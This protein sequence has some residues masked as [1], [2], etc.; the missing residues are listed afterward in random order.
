MQSRVHRP[1][2]LAGWIR[3]AGELFFV[4]FGSLCWSLD[5]CRLI[6]QIRLI[7]G[8]TLLFA[9]SCFP[10]MPV[11]LFTCLFCLR[12]RA[13]AFPLAL[14]S[15][16]AFFLCFHISLVARPRAL[17][18]S[19][20]RSVGQSS[21]GLQPLRSLLRSFRTSDGRRP[22][23]FDIHQQLGLLS[24]LSLSDTAI[25]LF[26]LVLRMSM[27][28]ALR[29]IDSM[30]IVG[31]PGRRPCTGMR[32]PGYQDK[33]PTSS[34]SRSMVDFVFFFCSSFRFWDDPLCVEHCSNDSLF[35]PN[36]ATLLSH[37][38][39]PPLHNPSL[40]S[41]LPSSSPFNCVF[42][43]SLCLSSRDQLPLLCRRHF[44]ISSVLLCACGQ[45]LCLT[46]FIRTI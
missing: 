25:L 35:T 4:L 19:V 17:G 22:F 23:C 20:G 31:F 10:R 44:L 24:L 8:L 30:E 26:I 16:G 15:F 27:L 12:L 40:Y 1:C 39:L 21:P 41:L 14:F 34:Y 28:G 42:S 37:I 46:T 29:G 9:H 3:Q 2:P 13:R 32:E 38:P 33:G 7:D 18:R 6:N 43:P 11:C 36:Q 5:L 45:C